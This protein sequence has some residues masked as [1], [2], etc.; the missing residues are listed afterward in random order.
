MQSFFEYA[1][2]VLCNDENDNV[3]SSLVKV[4]EG[5]KNTP[6]FESIKGFE[7]DVCKLCFYKEDTLKKHLEILHARKNTVKCDI[8][9]A[10]F[11]LKEDLRKH[12]TEVFC[13]PF[14]LYSTEDS[15]TDANFGPSQNETSSVEAQYHNEN[16]ND[17]DSKENYRTPTK[18]ETNSFNPIHP[19][20]LFSFDF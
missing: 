16:Q 10:E 14:F 18:H 1:Y 3:E 13:A 15:L 8:C 2:I 17:T 20:F 4:E 7:C 11:L 5:T 12:K 19:N 9:N 6:D